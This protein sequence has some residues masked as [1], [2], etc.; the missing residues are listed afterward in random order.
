MHLVELDRRYPCLA[1]AEL[2]ALAELG[3]CAVRFLS[4]GLAETDCPLWI[5]CRAA[6]VKSVDG[7]GLSRGLR[8]SLRR[9][10]VTLDWL[11]SRV[12][13]NLARVVEGSRVLE[14]FA[15]S[16]AVAY[17]A[18]MLGAYVVGLDVDP[19]LLRLYTA[20]VPLL[21]DAVNADSRTPPTKPFFDSAVGDAP[22]GRMS[23]SSATPHR[24]FQAVLDAVSGLVRKGGYIALALPNYFEAHG[25]EEVCAMDIHG[26]LRRVVAVWRV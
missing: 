7:Q 4:H 10:R 5:L 17:E 25:A 24:V 1:R 14:P 26:G 16:G 18:V 9:S 11:T 13:V 8:R 2:E 23:R 12:L 3:R 15:G 22:Y 6:L 21:G 20:N 19:S